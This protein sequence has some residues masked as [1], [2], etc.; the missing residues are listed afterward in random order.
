MTK[1]DFVHSVRMMPKRIKV[2]IDK[3]PVLFYSIILGAFLAG[4]GLGWLVFG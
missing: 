3:F 2:L 1:F 4:F